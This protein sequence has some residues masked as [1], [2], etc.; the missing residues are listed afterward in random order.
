MKNWFK[1]SAILLIAFLS[2]CT[3]E[4]PENASKEAEVLNEEVRDHSQ[5]S[6][7]HELSLNNGKR[8]IANAETTEG[9]AN[10]Q[11]AIENF[12]QSNG[13]ELEGLQMK[14][15]SEFR[16]LV[17]KC[18]MKGEAHNQLHYYIIPL[19]KKIDGLKNADVEANIKNLEEYLNTYHLYFK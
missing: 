4:S 11:Q 14:L 18:T 12:R 5:H 2:A 10:M 3:S 8:W 6:E 15:F 17:E 13:A 1:L 9:I 19:K 7:M 16:I